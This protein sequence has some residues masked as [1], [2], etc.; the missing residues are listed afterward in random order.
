MEKFA[1]WI[2]DHKKLIIIIT[3]LLIALSI[4]G[5]LFVKKNGDVI[6]YLDKDT[7]TVLGRNVL[8]NDFKI[9]ADTSFAFSYV[10]RETV[11]KIIKRITSS[12]LKIDEKKYGNETVS[13]TISTI[14]WE[15]SFTALDKLPIL[16]HGISKDEIDKTIVATKDM[17]VKSGVDTFGN[18]VDTYIVAIYYNIDGAESKMI[19]VLD[20]IEEEINAVLKEEKAGGKFDN[21]ALKEYVESDLYYIAGTAQNA[22]LMVKSSLG[23][24]PKFVAVA[25]IGVFLILLLMSK[26]Y[27]EPLIFLLTLGISILFNMGSNLIAGIPIG[28]IS[29]ITDSCATIL[30]LAIAMDFSIF[31]MHSY[32]EEMRTSLTSREAI[33]KALPKTL[34]AISASALTT[35]GGFFALFF[36]KY[37]MG[38]D[39]GFVLAKGVILSLLAV[40]FIQPILILMFDKALKKTSHKWKVEIHARPLANV[41]TKKW[42][43]VVVAVVCIGVAIPCAILQTHVPLNYITFAKDNPNPTYPETVANSMNNQLILMIPYDPTQP[44]DNQYEFT[45]KLTDLTYKKDEN[46][47]VILDENGK[48]VNDP[49]YNEIVG[50]MS[51]TTMLSQNLFNQLEN[52]SGFVKPIVYSQLMSGFIS[53][54]VKEN[55]TINK[56]PNQLHYMLY[57]VTFDGHAEDTQS[58][59]TMLA[60]K[61]LSKDSFGDF[62]AVGLSLG[63]YELSQVTPNDFMLV[64]ILSAIIIFL[65]LIINFR[66]PLLSL[67]LLFVIETGIFIN[68]TIVTLIGSK[69]NFMAYLIVS[70]IELG[71]TVDYAIL[72]TSKYLEEKKLGATPITAIKNAMFRSSGS[73][74]TSCTILIVVCSSVQIVTTNMIVAQVTQLISRGAF[75]SFLLVFTL[76]PGLL[77]MRERIYAKIKKTPIDKDETPSLFDIA[78][79]KKL[80][81]A[82]AKRTNAGAI[83]ILENTA[84]PV[85]SD[86]N[87]IVDQSQS[88]SLNVNSDNLDHSNGT[89]SAQQ[90]PQ[91][92]QELSGASVEELTCDKDDCD[93]NS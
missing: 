3:V 85:Q 90:A 23:E 75:L 93:K 52:S 36:M 70:A 2:I 1:K 47:K 51:L 24:M 53:N 77:A 28:T 66:K 40:V 39:L 7:D 20:T 59:E 56:D 71:A 55:G 32:Y 87:A 5:S 13:S 30:Q 17:F 84:T 8:I 49:R 48:K 9:I 63:A 82:A 74:M 80:A 26:S 72:F 31:L 88:S 69:I 50:I 62:R 89:A 25:V 6:S 10:P 37:K 65:I 19:S 44:I 4:I 91:S 60:I 29:S 54:I 86:L 76:L 58:Y 15:G 92:Q 57:V 67:M 38:Y 46:G 22:R 14:V 83:A 11:Q 81:I 12:S 27:I 64:N 68:L 35:V 33:V 61:Q 73:I 16:D 78:R 79:E 34:A 45:D 21:I 43:T 42:V 41:V 18:K